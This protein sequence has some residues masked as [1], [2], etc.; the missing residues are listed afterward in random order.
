MKKNIEHNFDP[1][2]NIFYVKV[3]GVFNLNDMINAIDYIPDE[4]KSLKY[5]KLLEDA[6]MATTTFNEESIPIIIKKLQEKAQ[7]FESIFH[8][9]I[10]N[11]PVNTAYTILIK[12][13]LDNSKYQLKIFATEASAKSWLK[14]QG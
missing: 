5:F 9:V 1:C 2:E 8:A 6:R 14:S 12:E 3:E 4:V 13:I 11:A 7:K 10:H